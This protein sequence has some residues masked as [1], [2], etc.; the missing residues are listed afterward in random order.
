MPLPQASSNVN[1]T[2]YDLFTNG[3]V[4]IGSNVGIGD[5]LGAL[6]IGSAAYLLVVVP[7]LVGLF[8]MS[9]Y[10]LMQPG[11][12]V[13]AANTMNYFRLA[14]KPLLWLIGGIILYTSLVV[15][16]EGW[17]GINISSRLKFFLEARYD[18][19]IGNLQATATVLTFAKAL[20]LVLDIVST[21]VFWSIALLFLILLFIITGYIISIFLEN[22]EKES[23]VFKRL[24]SA[25]ITTVIASVLITI[26]SVNVSRVFFT[27]NANI[28]KIGNVVSVYDGNVKVF[29]YWVKLGLNGMGIN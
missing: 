14:L 22:N 3:N 11:M 20:L 10:Y 28:N 29:K 2:T 27:N 7:F 6:T 4:Q 19:I 17:Y 12:N 21:F 5:L 16:L 25:A 24:F 1:L 15:L 18:L 9:K 23:T 26:Y 13:D 8:S